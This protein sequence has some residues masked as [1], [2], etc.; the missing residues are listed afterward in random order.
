MSRPRADRPTYSLT[1]RA[2]RWYVQWWQDGAAHRVSTWTT[3][4]GQARQ[5]LASFVAA[6]GTPEPPEQPTIGQILGGYL[7]DRQPHV[8]S[9]ATLEYAAAALKRHLADLIPDHLTR[10]RVRTYAKQRQREGFMVGPQD[11]RRRKPVSPGTVIR[12]IVTLRAALKW[13]VGEKWIAAAPPVEA[14]AAPKGRE[15]WLTRAEADRLL[16]GCRAIHVQVFTALALYTA[17]RASALL[18]LT[19][20][21]VDIKSGRIDLGEGFGKKR[22]A[23]IPINAPLM[24]VLEM[25]WDAH[26]TGWVIEHN[27][28]PISDIKTGFRAAAR[29]AKLPGVTPHVLRHTAATWMVQAGIPI[30]QIARFLGNSE[31]MVEKVYGHHSPEF[32]RLAADALA[33]AP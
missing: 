5:F 33:D 13:A 21:R 22:R 25:A 12:E 1:S 14:P 28:E 27:G 29:R 24:A 19:W 4:S 3:D 2:G 26:T 23:T 32:L 17:G 15:R 7:V 10:E 8:A 16:A 9:F 20:D 11:K 31:A 18:Q 30:A 6:Q